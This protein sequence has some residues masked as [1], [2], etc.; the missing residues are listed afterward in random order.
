VSTLV[1]GNAE[2][3]TTDG[4]IRVPSPVSSSAGLAGRRGSRPGLVGPHAAASAAGFQH[5]RG[6]R[7]PQVSGKSKKKAVVVY[8]IDGQDAASELRMLVGRAA[9]R[10]PCCRA[11]ELATS[12]AAAT[13]SS[14]QT[15]S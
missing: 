1:P 9:F 5:L 7:L 13:C 10:L 6:L 3:G 11:A 4:R 2:A 14:P 15:E 8:R 12:T